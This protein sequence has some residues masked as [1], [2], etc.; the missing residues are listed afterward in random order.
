MAN[1]A[2]IQ[3]ILSVLLI[4]GIG[5]L[6]LRET[7]PP[8][9]ETVDAPPQAFSVTRAFSEL[10]KVAAKPHP[11][12]SPANR[13]VREW[14]ASRF[15]DFGLEVVID[16]GF[17]QDQVSPTLANCDYV[18]NVL[19][20]W[21]GRVSLSG[22]QD[23]AALMIAAH[24]DSVGTG[25]GAGDDG[26]AVAAILEC[27]RALSA[28]SERPEHDVIFLLTDGEEIALLGAKHW[29]RAG[30]WRDRVKA[31]VNFEA[32]G[33]AGPS[34]LFE[35]SDGNAPYVEAFA[36]A[37]RDP[38]GTS[39]GYEI[40]RRMPNDTDFSVFRTHGHRGLNFAFIGEHRRYHTSDDT[41]A[42][43]DKRS[44]ERHGVQMLALID[45]LAN[46]DLSVAHEATEN[47]IYFSVL[48]SFVVHYSERL[49]VVF[50]LI[51]CAVLI[52]VIRR[53]WR[54]GRVC[55]SSLGYGLLYYGL[56]LGG[57]ALLGWL[58]LSFFFGSEET[59]IE[60]FW[61]IVNDGPRHALG[62]GLLV[63][64]VTTFLLM[65]LRRKAKADGL[66]AAP[67]VVNSVLLLISI[68]IA[69]GA[70]YLITWPLLFT[71]LG[72]YAYVSRPTKSRLSGARF[73]C[74]ALAS[75]PALVLF[76]P[77]TQF[78]ITSLTFA[79]APLLGALVVL[80]LSFHT[81]LLLAAMGVQRRLI[82]FALL[83]A[84]L[85]AFGHSIL[86]GAIG[87]ERPRTHG[88][89]FVLDADSGKAQL[90]A[91]RETAYVPD[92]TFI[93]RE[94]REYGE[95]LAFLG[96]GKAWFADVE[97]HPV[98]PVGVDLGRVEFAEDHREIELVLRP[99][100]D[101]CGFEFKLPKEARAA[102]IAVEGMKV[103]AE[104]IESTLKIQ[105]ADD[106]TKWLAVSLHFRG[107]PSE[108]LRLTVR[109]PKDAPFDA[110]LVTRH[111]GLPPLAGADP[112]RSP[113]LAPA[114]WRADYSLTFQHLRL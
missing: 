100:G 36:D 96:K 3:A 61:L 78:A 83:F 15:R 19:A 49:G 105:N 28:R 82:P 99:S 18:T 43:L 90:V 38:V 67:L 80:G 51:A 10:E 23:D 11:M 41:P 56:S 101:P 2:R 7:T 68:G 92:F 45:R 5:A 33:A 110:T 63:A 34:I 113:W 1:V 46:S 107:L 76:S 91:Q 74:V 24:H 44:L 77:L 8:D 57:A 84:S 30:T 85:L 14:T 6:S 89:T 108:G 95:A 73:A 22:K 93:E 60:T 40:Y 48:R 26:A 52:L 64:S 17:V 42:N 87:T 75:V 104:R 47:R 21:P 65:Q 97:P 39:L 62:L 111:Y 69:P 112:V 70:T 32:R 54:S 109:I 9:L 25:P 79:A 81:P 102:V 16:Q 94:E 103:A 114:S 58:C 29:V 71:S 66:V 53:G 35:T 37:V 55:R 13:E 59:S 86:T 20:R 106:A 98:A 72:F 4:L 50:A 88:M 27:A 12:N 31:I